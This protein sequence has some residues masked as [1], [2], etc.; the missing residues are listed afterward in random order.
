M[1]VQILLRYIFRILYKNAWRNRMFVRVYYWVSTSLGVAALCL[2][3]KFPEGSV[4]QV[5]S[6]IVFI[7]HQATYWP[8]FSPLQV[9]LFVPWD[10][11]VRGFSPWAAF[12]NYVSVA[13][14]GGLLV[15]F[16][17]FWR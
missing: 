12:G 1:Q 16:F 6:G 17:S 13:L 4:E 7:S 2:T 3:Y 5:V 14:V 9:P 11:V 15:Y 8:L 10:D